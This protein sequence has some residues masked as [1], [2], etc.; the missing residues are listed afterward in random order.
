MYKVNSVVVAC[1]YEQEGRSFIQGRSIPA[2]Y[3]W[4]LLTSAKENHDAPCVLGDP[5]EN[6][7]LFV[8]GFFAPPRESLSTSGLN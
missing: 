7:K 2:E 6:G 1:G 3:V 5:S 4:V 8:G